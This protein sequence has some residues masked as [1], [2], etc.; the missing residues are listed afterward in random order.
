MCHGPNCLP[1]KSCMSIETTRSVGLH[2]TF[3]LARP[4]ATIHIIPKFWQ[5]L[6]HENAV[7]VY[8]NTYT[9]I[10]YCIKFYEI[11][12]LF[13]FSFSLSQKLHAQVIFHLAVYVAISIL[14][15]V[16]PIAHNFLAEIQNELCFSFSFSE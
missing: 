14:R 13:C 4:K 16:L 3:C 15:L 12:F 9:H 2:L 8:T 10:I 1:I 7:G 6:D 11:F 5:R